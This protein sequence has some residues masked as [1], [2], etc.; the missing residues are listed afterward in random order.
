M[1][2]D[3]IRCAESSWLKRG[4]PF[5]KRTVGLITLAG[6]IVAQPSFANGEGKSDAE[7]KAILIQQSIASYSG[8]C[9]CPYNRT[10][11]GSKCGKR[12]AYSKPGGASPLC[13]PSDVTPAMVTRYRNS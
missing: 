11:N 13:Y 4:L 10:S 3:L 12:S 7:I 2:S 8:R 5:A 9:P 6:L 1:R